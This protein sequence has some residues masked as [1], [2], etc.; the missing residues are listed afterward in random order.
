[1]SRLGKT[2]IEPPNRMMGNYH[3]RFLG[4]ETPERELTYPVKISDECH[5]QPVFEIKILWIGDITL[6][7]LNN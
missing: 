1:M 4:G 2:S 5:R 7:G 6:Y 3:V